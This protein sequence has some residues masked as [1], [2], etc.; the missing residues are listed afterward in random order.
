M[1]GGVWLVEV[2]QWDRR[3]GGGEVRRIDDLEGG[4]FSLCVGSVVDVAFHIW[5]G[6]EEVVV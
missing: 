3:Y 5:R 2:S 6:G 1:V 4:V